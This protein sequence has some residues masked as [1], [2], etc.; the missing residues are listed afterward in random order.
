METKII[1]GIFRVIA[2]LFGTLLV[3]F[4]LYMFVGEVLVGYFRHDTATTS[5]FDAITIITFVFWGIGL[6]G[7]VLAWWKEGLGGIISLLSFIIFLLLIALNPNPDVRFM[8]K[9]C[10][11]LVPSVLYILCWWLT[12]KPADE[13]S[14]DESSNS[15]LGK[16]EKT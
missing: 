16:N 11:F 2:R 7:L 10:I 12:G 3:V 13:F 15:T 5:S 14:A 6:A 4:T 9:L 8:Y 1:V